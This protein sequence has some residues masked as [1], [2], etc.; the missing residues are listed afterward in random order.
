MSQEDISSS[1]LEQALGNLHATSRTA[2]G[3]SD[4]SSSEEKPKLKTEGTELKDRATEN[5]ERTIR[6]VWQE[7]YRPFQAPQEL[8]KF[9]EQVA[10]QISDG[11]LQEG[12]GLFRT[13]DTKFAHQSRKGDI[14]REFQAF[15]EKLFD[16]M[17]RE[18]VD[19]VPLAAWAEQEI[20]SHVHPFTDGCGRASKAISAWILGRYHMPLPQWESRDAYYANIDFGKNTPESWAQYYRSRIEGLIRPRT[21]YTHSHVDRDAVAS[22]WAYRKYAVPKDAPVDVRFVRAADKPPVEPMSVALDIDAGIKGHRDSDGTTHSCFRT[23]METYAPPRDRAAITKLLEYIDAVDAGG[24]GWIPPALSEHPDIQAL[25]ATGM[26]AILE[27][28]RNTYNGDDARLCAIFADIFDGMLERERLRILAQEEANSA[29]YPAGPAIA[30]IREK[31]SPFTNGV[32]FE[33]GAKAVIY[34]D[35]MNLGVVRKDGEQFHLGDLLSNALEQRESGWYFHPKG[36]LAARGTQKSQA[37][38][39]SVILPEEI[40]KILKD[41]I[42]I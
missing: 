21:I 1:F 28:L 33:R 39:P 16:E 36:Y 34:V 4:T 26:G 18:H 19:A 23:L 22:L 41:R 37:L 31:K 14:E 29:E 12:Q 32:L 13:H 9:I 8:R 24:D 20:D 17:H 10:A 42:D 35:G 15:I 40:A 2:K 38:S 6:F 30:I 25:Q 27:A 11:L 3:I 7:R 5:F